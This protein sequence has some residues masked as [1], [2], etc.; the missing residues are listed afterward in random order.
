VAQDARRG[1]AG[2]R[3]ADVDAA[4]RRDDPVDRRADGLRIGD[5]AAEGDRVADLRRGAL[6]RRAVEVEQGDAVARR[7]P[8]RGLQVRCRARP[9]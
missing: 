6:D 2:V 3:D 5:V 7:Q 1:D 9:R 4:A 8:A